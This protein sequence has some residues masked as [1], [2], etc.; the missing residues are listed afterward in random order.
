MKYIPFFG[1]GSIV[2]ILMVSLNAELVQN[3]GSTTSFVAINAFLVLYGALG[4]TA[5]A[6]SHSLS[7]Q[8]RSS[9]H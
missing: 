6:L 1:F 5:L 9:N 3:G 7:L 8:P 4:F 2:A